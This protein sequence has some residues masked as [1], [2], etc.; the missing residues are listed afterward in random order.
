VKFIQSKK[1][2]DNTVIKLFRDFPSLKPIELRVLVYHSENLREKDAFEI[3]H[4][5]INVDSGKAEWLDIVVDEPMQRQGI[6]SEIVKFIKE[7]LR[8]I[9]A[10]EIWGEI[11]NNDYVERAISFWVS[12]GFSVDRNL[13]PEG[14]FVAKIRLNL[15][16]RNKEN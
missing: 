16:V 4:A 8:R 10:K 7:Y 13:N 6:G 1:I 9:G 3:A 15:I 2:N 12:N 14:C 5:Y 11:S